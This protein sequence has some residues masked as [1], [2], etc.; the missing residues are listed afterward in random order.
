MTAAMNN[1]LEFSDEQSMI[2]DSAREFCR[3][4][5]PI[6]AVRG[7]LDSDTGFDPAVWQEMVGLGWLGLAIPEE[8]GGSGLGIGSTVPLAEC[9]GRHMLSTPY[10]S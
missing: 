9:M 3:D 1:A 2:L 7:L 4:K 6:S 5:S 8:F 10:F